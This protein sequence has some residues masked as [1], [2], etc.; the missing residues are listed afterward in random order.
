MS[1][2]IIPGTYIDVRADGLTAAGPISTGNIGIVGTSSKGEPNKVYRPTNMSHARAIFGKSDAWYNNV[3][4][5]LSL[6]RALDLIFTN[7]GSNVFAV[8]VEP[9][10]SAM[11]SEYSLK[12]TEDL[13]SLTFESRYP[14]SGYNGAEIMIGKKTYEVTIYHKSSGEVLERF[15]D[16]PDVAGEAVGRLK[17]LVMSENIKFQTIGG[18]AAPISLADG[19]ETIELGA[20][21]DDGVTTLGFPLDNPVIKV[22]IAGIALS[23]IKIEVI[24]VGTV[25]VKVG[26]LVE[27]WRN[28]PLASDKF[29]EVINGESL[30]YDYGKNS[31]TSG[32]GQRSGLFTVQGTGVGVV[33]DSQHIRLPN[34]SGS[35]DGK[36]VPADIERALETLKDE[37]VQ[38][39]LVAGRGESVRP[40]LT[41]HVENASSDQN[42]R[43]RI[44][45]IGTEQ[46]VEGSA[47]LQ[48]PAQ[49]N[50][51]L[52]YVGPGI[53]VDDPILQRE[54]VLPAAYTAAALAGLLSS[55]PP[56]LSP[57]N[58][59]INANGLEILFNATDLEQLVLTRVLGLHWEFES[60]R[61]LKGI[62]TSTDTAWSQITTRRIVDYAKAG[63]RKTCNPFIGK[64]NI[65]RTRDAM[66]AS[67]NGFLFS[68]VDREMISDYQLEVTATRD[69]EIRGI[70][71]VVMALAPTFSI[72]YVRVV[73]NLS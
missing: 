55:I 64:L 3:M 27:Q 12:N 65:P 28:V 6:V 66:K 26:R 36:M 53:R 33:R 11:K 41:A 17:K 19:A 54:V 8:R 70:A 9:G 42:G 31:S 1:E 10:G 22:E 56:H 51:R 62:T 67:L 35:S 15:C 68:M 50:G 18:G 20:D 13:D 46:E 2:M 14:G 57:T 49:D 24:E 63:V 71:Q 30:T 29:K 4:E 5:N 52:V 25:L 16:V 47:S 44:G 58:K 23:E 38:F 45:L 32:Q 43:E 59:T 40:L 61:V 34:Q 48:A 73:M 37:D 39:V 60:V 72:D 21:A 7:G 69:Q